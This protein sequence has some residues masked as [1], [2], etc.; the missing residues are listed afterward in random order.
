MCGI[1]GYLALQ[2]ARSGDTQVVNFANTTKSLRHR[3]P[4]DHGTFADS[5]SPLH[6]GHTRLSILD[7]SPL[8]HQPMVSDDRSLAL[9]YNGEIYNFR[10]LRS[11]LE[12]AGACFRG[13]SDTE[14]ILRLYEQQRPASDAELGELFRSLNGIFA[15]AIWDSHRQE[16]I[17]ARDALGVKPL[18][19]TSDEHHFVFASELKALL[20]LSETVPSV[21]PLA[22]NQYLSFS[23]A[24]GDRTLWQGA[25]RLEPGTLLRV[26]LQGEVTCHHWY[27]LPA[28]RHP[29]QSTATASDLASQTAGHLRRAVHRQMVADVPLGAFLSGGL[30]SSSLV[31]FARELNPALRCFTI[32]TGSAS[33]PGF[34]VDLPYARLA[35]RHLGVPL[36]VVQVTAA[37]LSRELEEMVWQLDEPLADPAPLHVLH[38]CQAARQAGFKVMLSGAGGDDIFTGYPRHRALMFERYWSFLPSALRH[39]MRNASRRLDV[40]GALGRRLRKGLSGANLDGDARLIHYFR[41]IDR[42]DLVALYSPALRATMGDTR[43]EEPMHRFLEGLPS[44]APALERMLALEQRFFLADHNLTYTDKMSMAVGVEVRVPFLDLDL[45]DFAATVPLRY[46]QRGRHGKWI[47]KRAMEPYLPREL[48]YRPKTGFSAPLARWV[49]GELREWVHDML[50]EDTLRRRGLF[51]PAAV[52]RLLSDNDAGRIHGAYTILS[53]ACVEVWC[54]RFIDR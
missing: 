39:V 32:D 42:D 53:L 13:H 5:S 24:P 4:D 15:L 7:P 25:K 51:D 21:D 37:D 18:Y 29:T 35:A 47:L 26:N 1:I 54:R 28:F 23:W 6:L 19:F 49:R 11:E 38:I 9:S 17:V 31:A 3:G 43:A 46:K 45:V 14:V 8:G 22:L 30:D 2:G 44:A 33:D 40:R 27:Q 50:S 48:I 16:L 52:Q 12:A 34:A 20:P 10:E 36:D 41:G